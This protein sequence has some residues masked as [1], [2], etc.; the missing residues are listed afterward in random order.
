V[1]QAFVVGQAAF[2]QGFQPRGQ[3]L[4]RGPVG[5]EAGRRLHAG[6]PVGRPHAV[7]VPRP[8]RPG[9]HPGVERH[10]QGPAQGAQDPFRV[11]EQVTGVDDRAAEG[12]EDLRLLA[13][14][15]VVQVRLGAHLGVGG[16]QLARVPDQ[17]GVPQRGE[18][19]AVHLGQ[20][21]MGHVLGVADAHPGGQRGAGQAVKHQPPFGRLAGDHVVAA[22]VRQARSV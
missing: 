22:G 19:G 2:G 14:A 21:V 17:V 15:Q 10:V 13:Q 3:R 12:L 9:Q 1:V 7:A 5:G 20:Q 18:R 16:E 6:V 8:G 11:G 4:G